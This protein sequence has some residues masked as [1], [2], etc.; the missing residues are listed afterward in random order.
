MFAGADWFLLSCT[1]SPRWFEAGF[2]CGPSIVAMSPDRAFAAERASAR[3]HAA[4]HDKSNLTRKSAQNNHDSPE[5][6][7]SVIR[8]NG[9]SADGMRQTK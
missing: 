9:T 8:L 5:Y 7:A 4:P 6:C 2:Q 1:I 3:A